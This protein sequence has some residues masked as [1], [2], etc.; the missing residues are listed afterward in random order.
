MGGERKR[1]VDGDREMLL[2]ETGIGKK[3]SVNQV[4]QMGVPLRGNR[5][6][7]FWWFY[8]SH[9]QGIHMLSGVFPFTSIQIREINI[10]MHLYAYTELH[11]CVH[12]HKS[13]GVHT[14]I[15]AST[16]CYM[17]TYTHQYRFTPINIQLLK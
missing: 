11:L 9:Q 17:Y 5:S 8:K 2:P 1:G 4:G 12:T 15:Y 6:R 7:V 13:Q 16:R 10:G 3:Q 14:Y